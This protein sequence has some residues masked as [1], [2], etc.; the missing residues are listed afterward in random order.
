M[1]TRVVREGILTSERVDQLSE[2]AELFYRRLMNVADDHGR[3]QAHPT[4]LR[5]ACYPQRVDRYTD[6][7]VT[8]WRDECARAGLLLVYRVGRSEYLQMVDFRQQTRSK[9]KYPD[10]IS[11]PESVQIRGD[12]QMNSG[13]T[14]SVHQMFS[15]G[16]GVDVVHTCTSPAPMYVSDEQ[17][18]DTLDSA[19]PVGRAETKPSRA[20]TPDSSAGEGFRR[21]WDAY[22]RRVSRGRAERAWAK[23]RPDGALVDRIVDAVRSA[24]RR[25]RWQA[26]GGKYVPYPATWLNDRGWEDDDL[27]PVGL[28]GSAWW[29]AAGYGSREAALADGAVP[30]NA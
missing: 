24:A 13:C 14:S 19:Q 29:M 25:D 11:T 20:T 21:F 1:P 22:P 15:L 6:A 17:V 16:V 9:S 3:Y 5:A 10:P 26:D 4:L 12:E 27:R 2:L 28:N 18:L 7:Q 8:E 23:L 30:S